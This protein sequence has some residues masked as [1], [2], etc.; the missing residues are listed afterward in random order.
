MVSRLRDQT[1]LYGVELLA[2]EGQL[3]AS[4]HEH[5][6]L[7]EAIRRGDADAVRTLVTRHLRHTRG[8]WAGVSESEA[9]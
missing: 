1:R 8:I 3:E 6:D 5:R 9:T 4:A 2:R 7:I